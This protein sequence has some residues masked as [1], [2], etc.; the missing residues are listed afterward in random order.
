MLGIDG[1]R[2]QN[3]LHSGLEMRSDLFPASIQAFGVHF[4]TPAGITTLLL[5]THFSYYGAFESAT[6]ATRVVVVMIHLSKASALAQC[7]PINS[8]R[9]FWL[10]SALHLFSVPWLP[11]DSSRRF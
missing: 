4:W 10:R 8:T 2:I 1:F 9:L 6:L 11:F 5:G 3:R 7:H